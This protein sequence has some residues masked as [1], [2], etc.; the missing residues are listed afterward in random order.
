MI[1]YL[2]ELSEQLGGCEKTAAQYKG[3]QET[4]EVRQNCELRTSRPLSRL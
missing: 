1:G 2:E 4:L 3:Y